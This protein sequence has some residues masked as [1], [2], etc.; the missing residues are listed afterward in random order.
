MQSYYLP[1]VFFYAKYFRKKNGAPSQTAYKAVYAA[2]VFELF[3]FGERRGNRL[4]ARFVS[5]EGYIRG[6]AAAPL[7]QNRAYGNA[8][9]RE[10]LA[11]SRENARD[12]KSVV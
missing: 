3:Y 10:H 4:F 6:F 8:V 5:K 2:H 11:H 1:R 9:A 12:R 7:L